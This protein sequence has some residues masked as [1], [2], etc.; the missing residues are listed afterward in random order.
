MTPPSS[1]PTPTPAPT[2]TPNAFAA[3]CG[4]PLPALNDLYGFAIK[5]Q[6]EPS[7]FK[8]VL[9][10]SPIVKNAAY[11]EAVNQPGQLCRTRIEDNPER[12]PCDHYMSGMS[13]EGRPGPIWYEEVNG[14]RVRC[15]GLGL[16]G[17]AP[18]CGLKA[19]NQ[20]LLD[21][22][23]PGKYIACAGVGSNGSCGV[24]VLAEDSFGVI[25]NSPAGLCGLSGT[26]D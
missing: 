7:R 26:L 20:Y 22:S 11:C 24:C 4:T 9:N 18:H 3:A 1:V 8:K 13:D 5:V 19:E 6:L 17:D 16:P 10:A 2:A 12:V 21:V 25:H 23:G 15:G 14:K